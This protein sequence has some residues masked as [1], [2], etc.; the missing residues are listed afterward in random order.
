M[1]KIIK[2]NKS[3]WKIYQKN[4][5]NSEREFPKDMRAKRKDYLNI[6]RSKS[7][8]FL[9]GLKN[10]KYV[11]TISGYKPTKNDMVEHRLVN[12]FDSNEFI[13]VYNFVIDRYY[14]HN[15]Y[16]KQLMKAFSTIVLAESY[17]KIVGHFR[18]NNSLNIITKVGNVRMLG[19]ENWK[20]CK[21]KYLLC[22]VKLS[23]KYIAKI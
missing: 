17:K 9:V 14:K 1:F 6:L 8:I 20:N 22:E 15:G 2:I 7:S 10:D 19:Y 13:Y 16:G 21:E 5:I 18:I 11:G 3:N 12:Y 4:I 23:K